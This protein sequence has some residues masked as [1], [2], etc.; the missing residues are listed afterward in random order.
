MLESERVGRGPPHCERLVPGAE[1]RL[2]RVA[3]G[4]VWKKGSPLPIPP[5]QKIRRFDAMPSSGTL[6]GLGGSGQVPLWSILFIGWLTPWGGGKHS[7][8]QDRLM[9]R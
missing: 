1:S 5:P 6:F 8:K 7:Y 2:C 4:R 3:P 9:G